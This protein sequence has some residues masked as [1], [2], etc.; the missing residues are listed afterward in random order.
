M[1]LNTLTATG[2]FR[3]SSLMALDKITQ[4]RTAVKPAIVTRIEVK[5]HQM[6]ITA[7]HCWLTIGSVLKGHSTGPS[8]VR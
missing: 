1:Q 7:I 3:R 2:A 4:Y 6:M 5:I 8:T